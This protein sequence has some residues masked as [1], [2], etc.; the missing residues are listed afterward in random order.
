MLRK[1]SRERALSVVSALDSA[2]RSVGAD[3]GQEW[4]ELTPRARRGDFLRLA[5]EKD[6]TNCQTGPT[7][8][9]GSE[10]RRWAKRCDPADRYSSTSSSRRGSN[11]PIA[12]RA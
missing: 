3:M 2:G 12:F 9:M 5:I 1:I 4:L 7:I 11:G 6:T 8:D 10:K